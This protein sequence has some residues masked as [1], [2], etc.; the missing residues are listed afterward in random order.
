MGIITKI[1]LRNIVLNKKRSALIG[2]AIFISSFLLLFSNAALNGVSKQVM[3]GYLNI[4]SGHVIVLWENFK[5]VNTSEPGRF[6]NS[7]ETIS[8]EKSK[9]SENKSSIDKM[10]AFFKD[11]SGEIDE[12]FKTVRRSAQFFT[13]DSEDTFVTYGLTD[14][15]KKHILDSKAITMESGELLSD[16]DNAICISKEKADKFKLKVGDEISVEVSTV[17]SKRKA[18]KFVISGIY[19]NGA[20]YDNWYGFMSDKAA[21]N[22]YDMDSEYF[23]VCMVYLKDI[24]NSNDFA[25]RL[26]T[27]LMEGST[28]LR[29]ESYSQAT[30]FYTVMPKLLKS[31]YTVFIVFLLIIIAAGLRSTI[32]M[33]LFER[34]KEFGSIRAIG[35]SREQT[36]AIIFFEI[37]FLSILSLLLAFVISIVPI[38]LLSS[39]G[40]YVGPGNLSNALGGETF[41]PAFNAADTIVAF[42]IITFFSLLSTLSPGIKLCYQ[43]IADIMVKRQRKIWVIPALLKSIIT[44][45]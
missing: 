6:V 20:Q 21:R 43:K 36:F 28:V 42:L 10:N 24:N 32:K 3:K 37:F 33:N 44:G 19:A 17:D 41:Y 2:L 34:M 25:G 4:Q 22:L 7:N 1:A 14:D 26:D 40:V 30:Q 16:K 23:D 18:E 15:S 9:D 35:Y 45:R 38:M 27:V 12:Y 11:N 8:F 5:K 31:L 13:K 29:A 39:K